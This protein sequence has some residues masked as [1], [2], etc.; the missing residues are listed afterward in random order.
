MCSHATLKRAGQVS[1]TIW[2]MHVGEDFLLDHFLRKNFHGW[3]QFTLLKNGPSR[4]HRQAGSRTIQAYV[5]ACELYVETKNNS[6][7]LSPTSELRTN[8][9]SRPGPLAHKENATPS[10]RCWITKNRQKEP[11]ILALMSA[12]RVYEHSSASS[13]YVQCHYCMFASPLIHYSC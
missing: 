4:Q 13:T 8:A 10:Y 11:V 7:H 9:L 5:Q 1:V 6:T 2:R 12:K 3:M